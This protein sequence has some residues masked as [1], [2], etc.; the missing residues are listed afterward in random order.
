MGNA[1]GDDDPNSDM[2]TDPD[3]NENK[4]S[5][6]E[7][8]FLKSNRTLIRTK[9][10]KKCISIS[11]NIIEYNI[12]DYLEEIGLLNCYNSKLEKLNEQ[13]S[14]GMWLYIKDKPRLNE[15]IRRCISYEENI[16]KHIKY[17]EGRMSNQEIYI[18]I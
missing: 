17:L 3:K 12:A 2:D 14:K 10:T 16:V 8:E 5:R 7:L 4:M 9:A 11:E 1:N 13:I 18:I 15:E 6:P